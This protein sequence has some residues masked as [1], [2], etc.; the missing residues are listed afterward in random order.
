MAH[1]GIFAT[2]DEILVKAGENVDSTGTTE[3]RINALSLQ[4]ESYINLISRYNWSDNYATINA[5][6][7]GILSEAESN[8][9][10]IYLISFNMAGYTTRVEAEDMVNILKVRFNECMVLL[11]DQKVVLFMQGA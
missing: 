2:S 7:R 5:D 10:A 3:A 8:L 6:V 1:T 4:A 11:S 9:V